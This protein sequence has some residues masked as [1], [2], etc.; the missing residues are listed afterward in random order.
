MNTHVKPLLNDSTPGSNYSISEFK[1][2]CN[3]CSIGC[4]LRIEVFDG[5]I[6]NVHGDNGVVN[7][8][9]SM[10][11]LPKYGYSLISEE[12]RIVS[13]MIRKGD[14]FEPIKWS[15]A[16]EIITEKV[17]NGNPG[18]QAFFAGAR[19]TNEEQYLVQKIARACAY[20]NNIG[21]FHY[22]G[23]GTSYTKLS[24]ANIP[25]AEMVEAKKV[26][27]IGAE[28]LKDNPV[29]GKYI[30]DNREQLN[31]PVHF[32]TADPSSELASKVDS[33]TKVK[34]YFHFVKAVNYYLVKNQ[35]EDPE[36]LKN[37]VDNFAQYKS[38]LLEN[39]FDELLLRAGV[40]E[41][42]VRDFAI[43]FNTEHNAVLVFSEKQLS[44]HTCG[45]IFNLGLITGKHGRT[46]AG[47]MLLKENNNTHGLHDIGV[48]W[49]LGPGATSW[50]D[51]MQRSTVQFTWGSEELVDGRGCTLHSL[52]DGEYKNIFIF[53]EDPVG[54]AYNK[55]EFKDILSKTEFLVVQDYTLTPTALLADLVIPASFPFE[56]GGT[57]T[58]CQRVIQKVDKRVKSPLEYGSWEFLGEILS[59]F[60]YGKFDSTDDIT[61]EIASLLP[62][63]CTSSKLMLRINDNDNYNLL[64]EN[65]CDSLFHN[66]YKLSCNE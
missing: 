18:S 39:D 29:A 25:F 66:A 6:T 55:E 33:V 38:S 63:F 60:G 34:S 52:R 64:F 22:L 23:R 32:V 9:G 20:T 15:Q 12:S 17:Q 30:F 42:V 62:K 43:D 21:S 50:D 35:L 54:C 51:P 48:M 49:N 11:E 13:P 1:T 40:S 45:E 36:Y 10:C 28:I 41:D 4:K 5:K 26:F 27:I 44:G 56:T 37:L 53:G 47:L 46:G 8:D 31:I 57:F 3:L 2:I 61:F 65:G 58:N 24:R 19:L 16:L 14:T 59:R 7:M